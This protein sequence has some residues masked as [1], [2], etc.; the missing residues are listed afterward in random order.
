MASKIEQAKQQ[1]GWQ[2]TPKTCVNC[3]HFSSEKQDIKGVYGNYTEEK[4]LRCTIG[5]FKV[6]KSNVCDLHEKISNQ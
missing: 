5:G 2:K 4:N 6:G 3:K 1:Q